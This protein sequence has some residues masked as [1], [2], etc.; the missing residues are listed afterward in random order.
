MTL[1]MTGGMV[2]AACMVLTAPAM[3]AT[4]QVVSDG[5]LAD[6]RQTS[7]IVLT[8][9]NGIHARILAYGAALQAYI[10]PDRDGR[11]DDVVLGHD[12]SAVYEKAH[13]YLGVTVGRYANRIAAGTFALDGAVF[14]LPPN[15]GANS[16]HGGG[17][18][19]DRQIWQIGSIAQGKAASVEL[20]YTSLDGA[21][22]Y[23]G[24]V[25]VTVTY[26]LSDTGDLTITMAATTDKPTVI[27]MTNH[28]LYNLG[29]E[30]SGH[31]AMDH[32]LTIPAARFTPVDPA[33]IP[34]GELAPVAGTVFD[35]T[36][37]RRLSDG[38]RDGRDAQIRA[39][40]GYDHNFAI[41][42]G[43][44]A[45]PKLVAR[46]H[47][48]KSGR[49]LDVLSTEPGVQLY[50]GNFLDGTVPGKGGRLYRMGDGVALE[51]QKFPDSPNQ[52]RFPSARLNPGETYRH[53]MVLHP[54]V[55]K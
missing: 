40:R 46:L 38:L 45:Q 2:M 5:R 39:G 30:A 42:A 52:P 13:D 31:D 49:T 34:T 9:G 53:V 41:D 36:T 37:P 14:H 43:V 29:G 8:A 47:D 22:G 12:T 16:L 6:G 26:S 33:L 23:P 17:Q 21:S 24:T 10:I 35:F 3:G 20:H 48:P 51:P 19:F 1:A 54:M 55:T 7:A 44:T 28:A 15:D 27:N 50:T 4:V 32:V 18:G 25:A 11:L